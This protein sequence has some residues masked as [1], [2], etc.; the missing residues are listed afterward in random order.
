MLPRAS[1]YIKSTVGATC[2]HIDV[3]NL[4][5]MTMEYKS[6]WEREWKN[7]GYDFSRGLA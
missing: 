3:E 1:A 2:K 7:R 6:D 4:K 5:L